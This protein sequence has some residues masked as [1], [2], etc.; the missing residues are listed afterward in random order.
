MQ[1][2]SK[3]ETDLVAKCYYAKRKLVWELLEAEEPTERSTGEQEEDEKAE[4][5]TDSSCMYG[6]KQKMEMPWSHVSY[7]RAAYEEG[8]RGVLDIEVRPGRSCAFN[9]WAMV[10]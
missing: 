10:W 6:L 1:W 7:L 9:C 5:G 3:Q 2:F 8:K 4:G